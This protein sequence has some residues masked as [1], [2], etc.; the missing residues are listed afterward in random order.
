MKH[1]KPT[2]PDDVPGGT[3]Q[4]GGPIDWFAASL[5]VSGEDL[6]PDQITCLLGLEPT[7]SQR[8]GVTLRRPDGTERYTPRFGR[9]A[10]DIKPAH[11]DEWDIPEVIRLLFDGLPH[12]LSVWN[13]I[14]ELGN[15]RVTLGLNVPD[16][17]GYFQLDSDVMLFLS[18]R[19]A[20]I[21]FDIYCK[22]TNET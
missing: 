21:W 18:D 19:H 13:Q 2:T 10:R 20:R 11:T 16:S 1:P 7:R 12:D 9:W 14:A 22:Q 17:N 3:T 4:L 8:R 6:D 15:I 5:Q